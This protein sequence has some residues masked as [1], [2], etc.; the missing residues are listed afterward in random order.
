MLIRQ[1]NINQELI[2]KL[3]EEWQAFFNSDSKNN[4]LFNK[5]TQDG[6]FP[7]ESENAKDS[8]VKDLKEFFHV[9]PW[10][11][12]PK[13]LS[14][15]TMKLYNDLSSMAAVMLQWIE[16]QTPPEIAKKFSMPLSE[17]VADSRRTLL[18]ILHY[19]PLN[20]DEPEGAIRAAA[21]EDINLLTLLT[22]ATAAG[23]QVKDA[24]GNWHDVP[25]D[26]GTIAVNAA[27]MLQEATD[28]YFVSTTH[29]VVNPDGDDAR[30]S[31]LSM[32]LFL[33]PR[34]EV[35]LSERYTANEYRLERLREL[36]LI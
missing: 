21:H 34:D 11:Q 25:C 31:R 7:F 36:G 4:Y 12:Y 2:F 3:Y 13:E 15:A 24:Q 22:T 19:P 14:Q 6:F 29:R 1:P 23:L 27:D 20:G 16:A 32:P 35:R 9:Y 5:E 8:E 30:R 10:G 18:R 26:P 33:H 28:G 17:M